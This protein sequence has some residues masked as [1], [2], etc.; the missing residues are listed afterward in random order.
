MRFKGP[1]LFRF[2]IAII[3]QL[4]EPDLQVPKALGIDKDAG[5]K[6]CIVLRELGSSSQSTERGCAGSLL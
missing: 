4:P 6:N 2:L 1:F 5:D 3:S